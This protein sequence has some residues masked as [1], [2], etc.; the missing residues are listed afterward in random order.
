MSK[1]T[2]DE[3]RE[4]RSDNPH[5][6]HS[7]DDESEDDP[8]NSTN[9]FHISANNQ[10]TK[11]QLDV[12]QWLRQI[13][14][15]SGAEEIFGILMNNGFDSLQL[16]K[17]MTDCDLES[18]NIRKIGW[19][20]GLLHGIGVLNDSKK[21]R[22]DQIEDEDE[23][24]EITES[25]RKKLK[26]DDENQEIRAKLN[27]LELQ[28]IALSKQFAELQKIVS[29]TSEADNKEIEG[30]VKEESI[31]FCI[32]Q[33]PPKENKRLT[34]KMRRTQ[35]FGCIVASLEKKF[36]KA[37]TLSFDGSKIENEWTPQY[38]I[39]EYDAKEG[40]LIDVQYE[41]RK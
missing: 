12:K 32:N 37:T 38:L 20:R 14:L 40:D 41:K 31:C 3:S 1:E 4:K 13:G 8:N 24:V 23:Y 29:Q 27:D 33:P 11:K 18:M 34:F 39:D 5:V 28:N 7:K 26:V 25:V 9:A 30:A 2:K 15:G 10:Q 19:K 16:I 6:L 21:S 35:S 17:L 36:N 22:L